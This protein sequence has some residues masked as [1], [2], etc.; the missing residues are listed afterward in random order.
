MM[1][2]SSMI[3]SKKVILILSS[4][5]LLLSKGSHNLK[6]GVS[7]CEFSEEY[8]LPKV[9]PL[10]SD[11]PP[12]PHL[13]GIFGGLQAWIVGLSKYETPITL[14]FTS[15]IDAMMWNCVAAYSPSWKDALTKKGAIIR[16]PSTSTIQNGTETVNL[17]TSDSRLMCIVNAWLTVVEDWVPEALDPMLGYADQFQYFLPKSHGFDPDVDACFFDNDITN[18]NER[19]KCLETLAQEKCY[20]PSTV[21][22]IIG[23]QVTE[24]GRNDGWNA[25]G[26]LNSDGTPCTSNCRRFTDRTGYRPKM[27]HKAKKRWQPLLEDDGRGYFTR[28]EHVT[29][30]IGTLG[31]PLVLSREEMNSR[32]LPKPDFSYA[33]ESRKVMERMSKLDDEK[34]MLIEF[35][36]DKIKMFLSLVSTVIFAGASFEQV[37]NYVVGV[38][39]G[40]FDALLLAWK[41]KVFHDRVRPTTFIQKQMGNESF[42]T[43][44]GPFSTS[45]KR[46]KGK[47]FEAYTR[48]MPHSEYV[49]G[50]ACICQAAYEF[51]DMWLDKVMGI[52]NS[53]QITLPMFPAGSSMVEPGMTPASDIAPI[54]MNNLLE[55]RNT[56]GQSRLDGGMHFTDSVSDAYKLCE[57]VGVAAA[58]KSFELWD[59]TPTP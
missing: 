9:G 13:T 2:I 45:N 40:D 54:T 12:G 56:C 4:S 34:K 17:H 41:E 28:Q 32:K 39:A 43:W 3:S 38:G 23:R 7:A 8:E 24:Y 22:K 15:L 37:L 35:F 53:T 33:K 48:V 14:R 20:A 16:T 44:P 47:N 1:M 19:A 36:D 42:Q 58:L 59:M 31:K 29:P 11:A 52:S 6:A 49:S 50:S 46:I 27:H 51:T 30:H 21:G 18:E 57:G 55:F 10:S 5:I 26:T 25:Y